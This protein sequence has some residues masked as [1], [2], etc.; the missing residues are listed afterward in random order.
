MLPKVMIVEDDAVIRE[1]Y[2]LKFEL[3][4]YPIM[5]VENGERALAAVEDFEPHFIL[6]DMMMPVMGGLE[7]MKRFN[8][9]HQPS[10]VIV[11][12]NISAPKQMEAVMSLGASAYWVKSDYTPEQVVANIAELWQQRG[13]EDA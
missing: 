11:F 5:A 13:P 1:I 10:E 2:A 7:F 6:L 3:E 8:P 12:S 9:R 4:G